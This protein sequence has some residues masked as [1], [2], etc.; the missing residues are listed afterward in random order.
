[1]HPDVVWEHNL[2]T[3]SPE[4]GTYRGRE[5]VAEL[6]ERIIEPWEYMRMIPR[7]IRPIGPS[8]YHVR[9]E[10]HAKHATSAMEVVTHYDQ[11]LE[12]DDGLLVKGQITTAR[13]S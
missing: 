7:E 9:G 2:G 13:V 3:G 10:L 5:R 4:E 11:Q 8:T 1:M 6:F 12:I